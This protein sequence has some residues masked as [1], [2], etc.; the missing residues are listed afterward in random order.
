[1]TNLILFKSSC[2]NGT[3]IASILGYAYYYRL[4]PKYIIA[5]IL[6]VIGTSLLNHQT[7]NKLAKWCDRIFAFL[8][9]L[10]LGIYIY[11]KE[12][13]RAIMFILLFLICAFYYLAKVILLKQT[14]IS[15]ACHILSHISATGL[16]LMIVINR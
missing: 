9:I 5:I 12:T 6:I 13:N 4:L 8:S 2:I 3:L 16:I 15:N 10:F 7:T 14:Y 1:M 11:S